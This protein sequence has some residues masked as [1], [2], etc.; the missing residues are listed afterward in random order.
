MSHIQPRIDLA[1]IRASAE[2]A[3]ATITDVLGRI[4]ADRNRAIIE[5]NPDAQLLAEYAQTSPNPHPLAGIPIALKDNIDTGDRMQTTAGSPALLTSRAHRDA[6]A[7]TQL[8]QSGAIPVAKA[9]MSEWANFRAAHSSS[10]YSGRGGQ[11]LNPHDHTR[12]PSGSSSGS[13]AAVA[14]GLVPLAIGSE[15]DGSI[16]SPSARCGVVGIKPTV[17]VVPTKGVVP[18]SASQDSPGPMTRSVADAAALLEVLGGLENLVAQTQVQSDLC[19]GVMR[20]YRTGHPGTDALFDEVVEQLA[21]AGVSLCDVGVEVPNGT[22]SGDELT[23]LLCELKDDL[24]AY[25]PMRGAS[26]PQSITDVLAHEQAN[27]SIELAHFGHEFFVQAAASEG[28]AGAAYKEARARNLQW[29]LEVCL[30]PAIAKCDV[31]IAA[32][33]APAWKIDV[34]NGDQGCD[35]RVRAHRAQCGAGHS[36]ASGLRA[37]AR[38]HQRS[39][40]RQGQRAAVQA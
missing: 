35:Q 38:L 23:V 29:A 30:E 24:N 1:T 39:G 34:T 19:I 25:L 3:T 32:S 12:C 4:A 11:C 10:G 22:V 36:G 31:L 40:E 16:I 33:Y 6:F 9:N 37:G 17:G 2:P 26:G 27:A 7:I 18:I 8:R 14:A 15:T 20:N 21:G 13:A 28:R 5:V